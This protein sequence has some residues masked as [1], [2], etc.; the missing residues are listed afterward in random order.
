MANTDGVMSYNDS[1]HTRH[2]CIIFPDNG[3]YCT[4]LVVCKRASSMLSITGCLFDMFV[5][6]LFRKYTE[7]AQRMILYLCFGSLLLSISY[8]MGDFY[9][10]VTT[11]CVVQSVFMQYSICH[12]LIWVCFIILNLLLNIIWSTSIMQYEAILFVCGWI[13]PGGLAALPFIDNIY[14]PAGAWCWM[15]NKWT[16]RFG[17]WYFWE[18][19]SF[20]CIFVC[21]FVMIF[22]LRHRSEE[23]LEF[24]DA[25][26]IMRKHVIDQDIRTLRIYPIVYLLPSIFPMVHR[27]Q[28]A[29]SYE[30]GDE[31]Y[32]FT[33]VLLHA[34]FAPLK[35]F[36]VSVAFLMDGRTRS[37]LNRRSF[38][39]AWTQ[40]FRTI[41]IREFPY[42]QQADF[43]IEIS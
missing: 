8:I 27:V 24:M 16:W 26:T 22:K 30:K 29:I 14:G 25:A 40:R 9:T 36:A 34:V 37:V 35:G 41:V 2:D 21:I 23:K 28:N 17:L 39:D 42:G 1:D 32:I 12:I 5:I 33:F 7:F 13:I 43:D 31:R 4:A 10:E 20:I 18:F 15:I 6:W 19:L 11:V 38:R 3:G